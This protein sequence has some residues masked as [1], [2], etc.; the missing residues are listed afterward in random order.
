M[1]QHTPTTEQATKQQCIDRYIAARIAYMQ[2][3]QAA[4]RAA[5][6][7]GAAS[8]RIEMEWWDDVPAKYRHGRR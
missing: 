4:E 2:A 1:A 7:L 3:T 6:E 8:A 5:T